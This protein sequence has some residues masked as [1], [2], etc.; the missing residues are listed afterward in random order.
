MELDRIS[1]LPDR[2]ANQ[3]A[4]GEVVERPASVVKEL[5]ENAVDAGSHS[6]TVNYRDGGK[7]LIQVAD[8]GCGMSETDARL[9]FERHA[10][11]KIRSLDDIYHLAS[12]G[13]RGEALPSIASIAEVEVRTRMHDQDLGTQIIIHGGRFLSQEPVQTPF[14]TQ[15]LIKNLFYNTPARRN[16]LKETSTESKRIR[17]EFLRVALCNPDISFSLYDNDVLIANLPATNLRQRIVSAIGGKKIAQNLLEVSVDTSLVRIEGFVGQPNYAKKN[18]PEQYL[19]VNGRFFR[20]NYLRK[21][22]L[23]AY[24][25]L[26]APETQPSYFLYL[27]VDPERI[28]VNVHPQKTEV[29]FE[30]ESAI[31]QFIN[32]AVRETLGKQGVVPLMDFDMDQ[33][34]DIP[35]YRDNGNFRIPDPDYRPDFNPF[36]EE[37]RSFNPSKSSE[38]AP[39]SH[40][41]S[42]APQYWERLYEIPTEKIIDPESVHTPDDFDEFD[43]SVKEFI[44]GDDEPV[45]SRFE[46]KDEGALHRMF[47]PFGERYCAVPVEQGLALIDLRRARGQVLY[48]QYLRMMHNGSSASQQ[49][50]F[51]EH[52]DLSREEATALREILPELEATGFELTIE[53]TGANISGIPGTLS[54]GSLEKT[55]H[56]LTDTYLETGKLP[57]QQ[58]QERMAAVMARNG[59]FAA[60]DEKS[61]RQLL[62]ELSEC[63]NCNYTPNGKPIS[64][65]LSEDEINRRFNP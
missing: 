19:F 55:L 58:Q 60:T 11:S 24:E 3:I 34:I 17:D 39:S 33:S 16:F 32:A 41:Q 7:T 56:E 12:F 21:A 22:V 6:I 40:K 47:I 4:A 61:I 45:Q 27:T 53:E 59:A 54:A 8:D 38:W 65:L 20:S 18:N 25:K 5:M 43:S 31:W 42:S 23:Q 28:D 14:G 10:T 35:V 1:I 64:I 37:E 26:I 52:V 15:F 51:P 36:E 49:M 63:D 44:E 13:F 57:L 48:E 2:V 62:N 46:W 30:N 9:A 29:K 50:L